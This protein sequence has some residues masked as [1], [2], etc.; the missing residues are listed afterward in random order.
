MNIEQTSK[1]IDYSVRRLFGTI[2]TGSSFESLHCGIERSIDISSSNRIYAFSRM[3]HINESVDRRCAEACNIIKKGT[4]AQVFSCEFCE[5][6]KNT[7]S[8]RTRPVA[9][10]DKRSFTIRK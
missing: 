4:L 10:S 7:F 1:S 6:S 5:I 3:L 2:W 9:A 8:Y